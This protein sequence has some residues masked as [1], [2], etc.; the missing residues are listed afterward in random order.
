MTEDQKELLAKSRSSLS[1]ARLLLL[2]G[3]PDFAA[4]RAYYAM[5]Y[6]AEALLEGEGVAYS[7]HSAVIAAFGKYFA[8]TGKIPVEFHRYLIEAQEVRHAGDY[9]E[10]HAVTADQARDVIARAEEFLNLSER[11]IGPLPPSQERV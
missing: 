8:A 3:Y 4:S 7:K 1:A 6:V 11:L 10:T 2:G 9:G 5:F